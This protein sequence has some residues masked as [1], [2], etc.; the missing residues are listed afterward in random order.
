MRPVSARTLIRQHGGPTLL[1]PV[2]LHPEADDHLQRVA[3]RLL[4]CLQGSEGLVQAIQMLQSG[5]R[6]LT[7][8]FGR[9]R[10]AWSDF[11]EL[12][13]KT[14]LQAAV[15]SIDVHPDNSR[16]HEAALALLADLLGAVEYRM[17]FAEVGA[18]PYVL[19]M[20]EARRAG[21]EV[22]RRGLQ[23]LCE[24]QQGG[25]LIGQHLPR[26]GCVMMLALETFHEDPHILEWGLW[27]L[28][29]LGSLPH[30]LHILEVT[31]E[32][33]AVGLGALRA[34]QQVQWGQ[35][36]R[37]DITILADYVRIV[38]T[39]THRA[40]QGSVDVALGLGVHLLLEAAHATAG[41]TEEQLH[42]GALQARS[43]AVELILEVIRRRLLD[44]A[45]VERCLEV[46]RVFQ[47]SS[48]GGAVQQQIRQSLDGILQRLGDVHA[49]QDVI[50]SKV[51][52]AHGVLLGPGAVVKIMERLSGSLP[53]GTWVAVAVP[54]ASD[55]V[56]R[57]STWSRV[58]K[59]RGRSPCWG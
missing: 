34:L 46:V 59:P 11:G 7:A 12:P 39:S 9:L 26:V 17:A 15:N 29:E 28:L 35:T 14:L 33:S 50:Q 48:E 3:V 40:L 6:V 25:A 49:S 42:A 44:V 55:K 45:T 51:L 8:L 36:E 37:A 58:S 56:I 16:V 27:L 21:L 32:T 57:S 23:I 54:R 38:G 43:Q 10:E 22:Q 2:L 18:L 53:C 41:A 20:M 47:A 1:G 31:G 30:V 4:H 5:P 13:P 24:L 52:W 19:L